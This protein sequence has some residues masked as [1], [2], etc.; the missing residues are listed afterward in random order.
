MS[1]KSIFQDD[2]L[3][4]TILIS[5]LSILMIGFSLYLTSHYFD[6]KFPTGLEGKSLC[7]VN[8]FFNCD[9]TTLSSVSNIFNVPISIFGALVGSFIL[10]GFMIKNEKME[11]TIYFMLAA[12]FVGCLLLF[13]YSLLVLRGLCPFCTLYYI[14]SGITFYLF[15]KRSS[16]L[17][18]ALNYLIL[19][20][21]ISLGIS[22][23]VKMNI[24]SKVQAQSAVAGDLIKQFYSLPDLGSPK[25]ASEFKIASA[26]NAP[27]RMVIF[28]DFECPSC[29][30]LSELVPL[31]VSRYAGKID[32][33]Y[34]YYPLDNSCN[35]SMDR[36]MHQYACKAAYAATCMPV[37]DF[38]KVHDEIFQ[39]QEKFE[40]GFIDQFIKKNKIEG[41]VADP[42]TK[43][44]VIAL[45]REAAPFNI[46]STPSY[47]I[48]GVKIEGVI[49]AD[50]MYAI[51]D[52]ILKRAGK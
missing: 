1:K 35:A 8:Q 48:N 19:F 32:I 11:S 14:V 37:N 24:E 4:T 40:A 25:N 28:S 5:C 20:S 10:F 41:C 3:N 47:L 46:K 30:A 42:K 21:V 43:E 23:L 16:S 33:Q 18:P 39:N 26:P 9:K 50:Q 38:A 17:K 31:L 6:L 15:Y 49:P 2:N 45:I 27:I 34:F 29:K 13:T 44:K 51:M 36:P 52:E 12:N 7:N 22:G